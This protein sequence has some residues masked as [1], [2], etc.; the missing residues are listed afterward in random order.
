MSFLKCKLG[1]N[2]VD[3]KIFTVPIFIH[4]LLCMLHYNMALHIFSF[5][6]LVTLRGV[7]SYFKVAIF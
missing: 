7:K 1:L 3:L 5:F 2:K 6:H 4:S